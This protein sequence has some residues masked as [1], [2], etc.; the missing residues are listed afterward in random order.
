MIPKKVM[1]SRLFAVML[2]AATATASQAGYGQDT[3]TPTFHRDVRPLLVQ[4]CFGCHRA[5]GW[6][7]FSV[8]D[9]AD[10]RDRAQ[11]IGEAVRSG[12]MPP[13]L[14]DPVAV[15]FAEQRRLPADEVET[16]ERW[17]AGGALEG[18]PENH[19]DVPQFAEGWQI[20]EPDLVLRLDDTFTLPATGPDVY[21][22]FVI[23]IAVRE[24]RW[25]RAVELRPDDR[26][27]VHHA[28]ML[29]DTTGSARRL[30]DADPLPGYDGMLIDEAQFP[31]GHFLGWAP[32]KV[33]SK[34]SPDLAWRLQP[35]TDMILQ[36]H[37]L[38]TGQPERV[39]ASIGLF[40]SDVAPSRSLAILQLGSKTINIPAGARGHLVEDDYVL[41][42]DVLM[43]SVYPHAHY[44]GRSMESEAILPDGTRR[45]LL[46][47]PRWDFFWQ[48]HYRYEEPIPL[49]RG[50]RIT[51]RFRYDN[52]DGDP[53]TT[54][55]YGARSSDEMGDLLFQ[56]I[57]AREEE[58][59][60]LRRDF[61][62]HEIQLDIAGFEDA[63][64]RNPDDV[65]SR[66]LLALSYLEV[67]RAEEAV[68]A[69]GQVLV[70]RPGSSEAHYNLGNATLSLGRPAQA[71]AHFDRAI[72]LNPDNAEAHNN[73][74][75]LLQQRGNL[76]AARAHYERAISSRPDHAYARHNLASALMAQGLRDEAIVYLRQA[77][78][79]RPG[80]AQAHYTL[81]G[82]LSAEG[83]GDEAIH[84]YREAIRNQ[85]EYAEARNN[86]ASELVSKGLLNE[87]IEQLRQ[88]I[89]RR[90]GYV[91]AHLNLAENLARIGEAT[92]AIR[93]LEHALTLPSVADE[94]AVLQEIHRRLEDLRASSREPR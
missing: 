55:R 63:L 12:A 10:V 34:G 91:L 69:L 19:L 43:V 75:I 76:T 5:S 84:H 32:G 35:G 48:D 74:A 58:L 82:A 88:A 47:I 21:R 24:P 56:V 80:Y 71:M 90:P 14:P 45:W 51:M 44:L 52:L 68:A 83:Q 16:I 25:V 87:A 60:E 15:T 92:E 7:P 27:L 53:T 28:R 31:D 30:D 94:A 62:H 6:A 13:W 66:Q 17:V 67:G 1:K 64:A 72:E 73:L 33:A 11:S 36:L 38:P 70:A 57:P 3:P 46:R 42:H 59:D 65:D 89:E 39:G 50:T 20:G 78:R 26:R 22:N 23:P 37:M 49:P 85:P 81:A 8:L 41:P 93:V 79:L 40:F 18:E 86:L 2:T 4:R 29:V 77:L 9:F 54:V 61:L